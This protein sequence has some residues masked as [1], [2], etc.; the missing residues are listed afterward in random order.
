MNAAVIHRYGGPNELRYEDSPDPALLPGHVLVETRASSINPID[1]KMR[2][3]VAKDRFPLSFPAI[4][5]VDVSGTV[6]GV[7]AGVKAFTAGDRVFAQ[8]HNAYATLCAVKADELAHVPSGLDLTEAAALPTVTT[9]GV[10]LADLAL[11]NAP[12]ATVVVL[13]AVGNVGRSAVHQLKQQSAYVIAGVSS[14][15][16]DG[17][18]RLGADLVVALDVDNDI[19]ALPMVD[20][21]ADTIDGP[22]AA[23]VVRK[24]KPG[25]VFASVL[26]PPLNTD[27]RD[28]V[29]KTMRVRPDPATLVR[30]ARAVQ[31][32][33]L[34]IP[35]GESFPLENASAAHAAAESARGGKILLLAQ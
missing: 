5:G 34:S 22:T 18:R 31:N 30:M 16:M 35:I 9:T 28:I 33:T 8:A 1:L 2:S 3:G 11:G 12:N 15:H 32:G 10:Q 24:L 27:R 23:A 4:L 21:I 19:D 29:I 20:A 13:G 17:A 7:G 26:G 14:K 6:V 25:G